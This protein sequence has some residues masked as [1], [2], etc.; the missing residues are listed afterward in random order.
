VLL[1]SHETLRMSFDGKVISR[2]FAV[3]ASI[4]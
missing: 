1:A 2:A 3:L 4:T